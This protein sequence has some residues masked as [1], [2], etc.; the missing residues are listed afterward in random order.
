MKGV[1]RRHAMIHVD[2]ANRRA[3]LNDL[4]STNGTFV[5]KS[6]VDAPRSLVDGDVVG[7]GSVE[8]TYREWSNKATERTVPRG[9]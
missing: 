8:L 5:G 3:V 1:S 7:V 2:L 9:H 6:R 4:E